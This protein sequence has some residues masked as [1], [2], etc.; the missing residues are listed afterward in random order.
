MKGSG[1]VEMAERLQ[2]LPPYLFAE[3]DRRKTALRAKG[4]DLIDLGV[5]DPDLPTPQRIV[6]R[7][8]SAI[9]D[10]RSHRYPSYEGLREF[11]VA[12]GLWYERRFGVMLDPDHE[13]LALIGSKEG[14]AHLPLAFINPGAYSLVPSPGYPVYHAGTIFAGGRSFFMPLKEEQGFLPDLRQIP[15]EVADTATLLFINYPNNPT[16]AV[17]NTEFFAEVVEFARRHRLIVCHDAAYS[18]ISFDNYIPPSF[19]EV[20]GAREVGIEFH[21]LSKTYNMTGWR[22][23]F[24]VGNREILAG[25]GKAKTNIDSGVFQAVQWAGIEALTGD[26]S[27]VEEMRAI[28]QKRRDVMVRGLRAV[29]LEVT[30]PK[31]TFYLWVKV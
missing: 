31:A 22:L 26:Q 14:I 24:A 9:L 23:G 4:V 25:L 7:M 18:E 29:G 15:A 19:L 12:V 10:P 8:Q 16:S 6:E 3:L 30:P 27:D 20:A 28:Y 2:A 21:S 1:R 11:R 13:V 17:A 5:G